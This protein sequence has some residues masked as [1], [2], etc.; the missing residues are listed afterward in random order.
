M[1][2]TIDSSGTQTA[3]IGTE[4]VLVAGSTTNAT[5]IAKVRLNNLAIG[6]IV[7]LRIYTMT[8][9]GGTLEQVWKATYGPSPPISLV[10][11]SPP[12]ASDQSIKLTLK[13]IAGTGRSFDWELLRF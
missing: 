6:D 7:E 12:L 1:S 4:H 10:A 9:S 5:Y 11:P 3:T 13:Q 2:W 8:L